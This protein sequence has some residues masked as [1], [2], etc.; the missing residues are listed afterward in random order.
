MKAFEDYLKSLLDKLAETDSEFAE[1][2]KRKDKSVSECASVIYQALRNGCNN[3]SSAVGGSDDLLIGW[4]I[5]Y[6]HEDKVDASSIDVSEV[7]FAPI[8]KPASAP[9]KTET[10]KGKSK[11]KPKPKPQP[12]TKCNDF[13]DFDLDGDDTT[14]E[15]T[16][17][18]FED[19]EL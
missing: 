4:A 18:D 6:Y 3:K 10:N 19:F 5:H 17:S 1:D 11:P 9:A 13:D 16:D 14:T 7:F 8:D 2:Y 12:V 15:T